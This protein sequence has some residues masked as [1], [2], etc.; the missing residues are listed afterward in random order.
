[1]ARPTQASVLTKTNSTALPRAV[2]V[3][4][5]SHDGNCGYL[6][7]KPPIGT[8]LDGILDPGVDW[9]VGCETVKLPNGWHLGVGYECEIIDECSAL[10]P[11]DKQP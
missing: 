3:R 1:M 10:E 7:P 5:T 9:L 4:I 8:I 6:V 11:A 2:K